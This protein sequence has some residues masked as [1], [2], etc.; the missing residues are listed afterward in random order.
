MTTSLSSL[1]R[2]DVL[3]LG[4]AVALP[5]LGQPSLT[6]KARADTYPSRVVKLVSPYAPGGATDVIARLVA[7]R[8]AEGLK[9]VFIVENRPGAGTNIGTEAVLRSPPDGY[10]LLLASTANAANETLYPKL[11]FNFLRDSVPIGMIGSL[12]N[13]L[14]VH[15]SFP[16]KTIEE[17][18]AYVKANPG[19]VNMALPGNG[20]PQ[21]LSAALFKIMT[22]TDMVFVQ[23]KGGGPVLTDVVGGHVEAAFAS[24]AS[25]TEY[26]SSGAIR[27][28]AITGS[29]RLASL[30]ALPT[31][32]EVLPGYEASNCYGISGPKGLP[33]DVVGALNRELGKALADNHLVSRL[34]ALGVTPQM[35]SP[36]EFG[37]FLKSETD[38]WRK[39]ID[40][41]G[42]TVE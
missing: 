8:L 40:T 26:I 15:P 3:R 11:R 38:K 19:K 32:G 1:R 21:H 34:A 17:F 18:I 28:L 31:I 37:A 20:S 35:M 41:T 10:T 23:Y 39:V 2:R 12:P 25:S 30:P 6:T 24:S 27:A 7:Q 4:G 13:V 33:S 22:A 9:G 29:T 14:V 36:Q 42:I 16:A 5:S